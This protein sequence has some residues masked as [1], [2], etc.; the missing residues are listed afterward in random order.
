MKNI[1]IKSLE[2]SMFLSIY[3]LTKYFLTKYFYFVFFIMT[4]QKIKL[5]A[6][7]KTP[8]HISSWQ[9]YDRMDYFIDEKKLVIVKQTWLEEL[10]QKD[11]SLFKEILES[12]ENWKFT[13]LEN[14][15]KEYYENYFNKKFKIEEITIEN[16]ALK[17]LKNDEEKDNQGIIK[18]HFEDK[19][20]N[21]A[22]IP[23]ST[24]KGLF[25]TIYFFDKYGKDYEKHKNN[26]WLWKEIEQNDE[27]KT[28]FSNL[29]F[30]DVEI[31]NQKKSIQLLLWANKKNKNWKI[32]WVPQVIEAVEK[33]EFD[34]DITPF[35]KNK[36][37]NIDFNK[38]EFKEYIKSYSN[39]LITREEQI[40]ENIWINS[41]FIKELYNLYDS[42][43][44]PI[45][46]WMFKKS[47]AYKI[48]WEEILQDFV[49]T[50]YNKKIWKKI[51]DNKASQRFWVWDK[52]IYLDENEQPIWWI[53]LEF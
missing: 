9:E 49:Y 8:I 27:N 18:R 42:W 20:T 38:E 50:K 31:K 34:I 15:K 32:W 11:E 24:L 28:Y 26:F 17:S 23:W 21:K 5:K 45:K 35:F 6:T 25:R 52:S 36:E 48:Y 30:E 10:A 14:L 13:E 2:K 12:I 33:G 40:L 39:I 47:L 41:D 7:I 22:M 46:I 16:E 1:N 19:F 37:H 51:M 43:K 4:L 3:F 44:Y 53:I 29:Y